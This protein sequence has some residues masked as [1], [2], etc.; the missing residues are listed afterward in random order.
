MRGVREFERPAATVRRATPART[1][2]PVPPGPDRVLGNG[3]LAALGPGAPLPAGLRLSMAGVF[4][5]EDFADVRVHTGPAAAESAGPALAYTVGRHI[6]FGAGQY[7][8]DTE[9]GLRLLTHELTH[10]V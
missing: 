4:G 5:G 3:M 2:E 1:P 6:V 7:R 8:P 10:T 9:P